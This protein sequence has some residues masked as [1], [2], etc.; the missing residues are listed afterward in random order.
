MGVRTLPLL[1]LA[2]ALLVAGC[3]KRERSTSSGTTIAVIPK[4]PYTLVRL[5]G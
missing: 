5:P 4:G 3:G 1:L 2:S